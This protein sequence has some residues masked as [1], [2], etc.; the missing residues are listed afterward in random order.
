MREFIVAGNW[1]MN[2]S[3]SEVSTLLSALCTGLNPDIKT[4]V[5]VCPPSVYLSQA[6][7]LL[8]NT[9][10]KLGAQNVN[11]N[12]PGAHT[13]ELTT[14]M[15]KEF[16]AN[17][18]IVGHSERRSLYGEDDVMVVAKI[19]A[20]L[21]AG[22]TPIFCIGETLE[23]RE[24]G[25]TN[26]IIAV[27]INAAI[28]TLGVA[29]FADLI[30][31]YEPIWAIGT[32]VTASPEQA[33]DVHHFARN[34]VAGHDSAIADKLSILYGGSVNGGNAAQLFACADIDGGLVGGASLKADDFLTICHS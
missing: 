31:A 15:I 26:A 32:G 7:N 34:L 1:K 12:P 14:A 17:Y 23:Q 6:E 18:I 11:A 25:Q 29:V 24:S 33:Q 9:N 21:A 20:V 8:A 10:I 30:V 22:M 2:T 19:K 4:T 3:K 5:I 27:Q 28:D 16:G 13:G